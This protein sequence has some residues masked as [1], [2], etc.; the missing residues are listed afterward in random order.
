MKPKYP[1]P[2]VAVKIPPEQ[3]FENKKKPHPKKLRKL[4]KEIIA[5][6][7]EK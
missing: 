6:E 2:R 4:V 3:V 5:N 7:L 1:K